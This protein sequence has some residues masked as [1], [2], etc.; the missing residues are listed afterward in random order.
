MYIV[1]LGQN[2]SGEFHIEFNSNDKSYISVKSRAKQSS[3]NLHPIDFGKHTDVVL[4]MIIFN[5]F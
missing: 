3:L 2:T 1:R 5:T 4:M